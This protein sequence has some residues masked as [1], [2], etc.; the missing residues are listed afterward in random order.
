[1]KN[2]TTRNVRLM[3][4]THPYPSPTAGDGLIKDVANMAAFLLPSQFLAGKTILD[5]G[6]GTAHRLL[7]FAKA[8]PKCDFLGIDMTA[9]SLDVAR[10]L[11]ARHAIG[12]VRFLRADLLELDLATEF[13]LIVSTGVIHCL[14][15]PER[16]L[17]NLCR[18]LAPD[19]HV[20][21]WHY[22]PYGEF[23]R[24]LDRE[25]VLT[26]WD[27]DE[28][29]FS[30]GIDIMQSLGISL[31]PERYS[32]A[33]AAKD[34]RFMDHTSID[35]DGYLHPIVHTYRFS[36]ALDMLDRC[37][38]AWAA[39][40][41]VSLGK[42]SKLI[43]LAQVSASSIRMFCLKNDDLFK[44]PSIEERYRQLSN[45]EKLKV[46]ELITKPN[47]YTLVSGRKDTYNLF[48]RRI[49]GGR[50]PF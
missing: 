29:P 39:I 9:A 10:E 2:E 31:S 8:F 33:H 17:A 44:S 12:N 47:G 1:M 40:H 45:R 41:S 32:G 6:C 16:G 34:N 36:Q 28:M 48:D 22:H 49:Q 19:G 13:D 4:E 18:H 26:F 21:L 35:V 25:L 46:I 37:G 24:L 42:D 15:D 43:D 38:M 7:G 5:A 11:A 30:E 20:I 27:R 14:E 3:Y 23:D 50:V